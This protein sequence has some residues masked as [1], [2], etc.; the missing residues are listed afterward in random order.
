MSFKLNR[1]TYLIEAKW[2]GS[3]IGIADLHTFHGKLEQRAAWPRG[4]F[5]SNSGF[6]DDGVLAFGRGKRVICGFAPTKPD[7]NSLLI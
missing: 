6:T 2:H 4:I 1:E 7:T 3:K 5:V